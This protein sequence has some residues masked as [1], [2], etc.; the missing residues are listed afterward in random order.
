MGRAY[1]AMINGSLMRNI[2]IC[3]ENMKRERSRVIYIYIYMYINKHYGTTYDKT[4]LNNYK[5]IVH[6]FG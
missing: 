4:M 5:L 1:I 2:N 6:F 3:N